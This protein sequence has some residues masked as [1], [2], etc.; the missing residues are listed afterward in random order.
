MERFSFKRMMRVIKWNRV[1]EH[2]PISVTKMLLLIV[3]FIL[4]IGSQLWALFLYDVAYARAHYAEGLGE[5]RNMMGTAFYVATELMF[6]T[7]M[8]VLVKRETRAQELTLPATNLERYVAHLFSAFFRVVAGI[9][10]LFVMIDIVQ[11]VAMG[12]YVGFDV[13]QWGVVRS[14]FDGGVHWTALPV[15]LMVATSLPMATCIW[16]KRG[17]V[18]AFVFWLTI[19]VLLTLAMIPIAM[20]SYSPDEAGTAARET[21]SRILLWV[22]GVIPALLCLVNLCVGYR[23]YCRAQLSS[24]RNP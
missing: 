1:R 3:F 17:L 24:Q 4:P 14:L 7:S 13:V 5:M 2:K 11:Y 21:N 10:C 19:L 18:Y 23:F 12:C 16:H 8:S 15:L 9:A 20:A 6:M 22:L